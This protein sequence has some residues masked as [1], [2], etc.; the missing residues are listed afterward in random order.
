MIWCCM[1]YASERIR[2]WTLHCCSASW[3]LLTGSPGLQ[4]KG[5]QK[6]SKAC[7]SQWPSKASCT[8]RRFD[9][10]A[11]LTVSTNVGVR[12]AEEA[13]EYILLNDHWR[14]KHSNFSWPWV[15]ICPKY[16]TSNNHTHTHMCNWIQIQ[17]TVAILY[18]PFKSQPAMLDRPAHGLLSDTAVFRSPF[19]AKCWRHDMT[20]RQSAWL[21]RLLYLCFEACNTVCTYKYIIERV[22]LSVPMLPLVHHSMRRKVV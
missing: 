2:V 7:S 3:A 4:E 18:I 13:S 19:G 20:Y 15:E 1:M 11:V 21:P 9:G 14:T 5:S 16:H 22:E 8:P 17:Y 6:H 10:K 12:S